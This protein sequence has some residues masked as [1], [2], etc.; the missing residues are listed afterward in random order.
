MSKHR[1]HKSASKHSSINPGLVK[2]EA[3][4][5]NFNLYIHWILLACIIILSVFIR[6]H[7]LNIPFERDEGSYTYCGKIILDGAIPFKDIGSQRL[8]GVFYAYS[9]IVLI[10][11]YSVKS[12]HIAFMV[13]NVLTVGVVYL[14]GKNIYSP[15]A[16]LVTAAS[17]TLMSMAPVASGFTIQSEHLV[18]FTGFSGILFLLL[19]LNREK[20]YLLILSGILLHLLHFFFGNLFF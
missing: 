11:G 18:A 4:K 14:I 16:G 20:N 19:F 1:Q 7:F 9:F 6:I 2:N 8:P 15:L 5:N 17:F 3:G 12:M 10:F 13:V